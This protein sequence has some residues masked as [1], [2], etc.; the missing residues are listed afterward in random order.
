[1]PEQ[2][3]HEWQ[4]PVVVSTKPHLRPDGE[5]VRITLTQGSVEIH[6]TVEQARS[7]VHAMRMYA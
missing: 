1:M 6:L 7:I 3:T 5:F 4:E 2:A